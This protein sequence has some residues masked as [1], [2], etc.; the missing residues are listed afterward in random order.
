MLDSRMNLFRLGLF[1]HAVLV[2][3]PFSFVNVLCRF[4]SL[5][6]QWY[7]TMEDDC[8]SDEVFECNTS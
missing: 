8:G 3:S 6:S 2:G 7:E 5:T 1:K 4:C